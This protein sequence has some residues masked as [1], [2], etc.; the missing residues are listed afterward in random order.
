MLHFVTSP[1]VRGI[2]NRYLSVSLVQR[3]HITNE[4][5]EQYVQRRLTTRVLVFRLRTR[6]LLS[7]FTNLN[8]RLNEHFHTLNPISIIQMPVIIRLIRLVMRH[9]LHTN[10]IPDAILSRHV[11]SIRCRI[12]R[13][14][15]GTIPWIVFVLINQM[16]SM[17]KIIIVPGIFPNRYTFIPDRNYYLFVYLSN[18]E[19]KKIVNNF[20]P[21]GAYRASTHRKDH[22]YYYKF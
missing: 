2:L 3:L 17:M 19:H 13:V 8:L 11:L 22:R 12:H 4:L 6:V 9:S 10:S 21:T 5:N 15:A 1:M 16:M 7:R 14:A 20:T 18:R